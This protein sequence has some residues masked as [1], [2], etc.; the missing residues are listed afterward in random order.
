MLEKQGLGILF[1]FCLLLPPLVP[2]ML[3]GTMSIGPLPLIFSTFC[4]KR[5]LVKIYE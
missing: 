3:D 2:G 4:D 5:A 1:F